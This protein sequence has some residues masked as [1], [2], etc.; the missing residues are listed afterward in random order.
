[1][2][3]RVRYLPNVGQLIRE[4]NPMLESAIRWHVRQAKRE[5]INLIVKGTGGGEHPHLP[6]NQGE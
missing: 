2:R 5:A 3:D 4:K 1:M 6:I